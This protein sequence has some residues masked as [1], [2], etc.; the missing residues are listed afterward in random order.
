MGLPTR[1]P[2]MPILPSS[3]SH[4][5]HY[6]SPSGSWSSAGCSTVQ[7]PKGYPM[8]ANIG[9]PCAAWRAGPVLGHTVRPQPA[10]QAATASCGALFQGGAARGGY[11]TVGTLGTRSHR[12]SQTPAAPCKRTTAGL[13]GTPPPPPAG[14][15]CS[16]HLGHTLLPPHAPTVCQQ[17]LRSQPA[18]VPRLRPC[19]PLPIPPCS[20]APVPCSGCSPRF[21]GAQ[22]C[23]PR[24][25]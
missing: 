11:P 20:R 6:S 8:V 17:C 2:V 22:S 4:S 5:P 24:C 9:H 13:D 1:Q 16:V 15:V 10:G 3:Y 12:L 19:R 14:W 23:C 25:Q 18:R 7:P 21:Q